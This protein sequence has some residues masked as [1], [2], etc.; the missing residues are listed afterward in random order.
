MKSLTHRGATIMAHAVEVGGGSTVVQ[1]RYRGEVQCNGAQ[2]PE[3]LGIAEFDA[4]ESESDPSTR[5]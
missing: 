3:S 1:Y 5:L 4:L 2:R